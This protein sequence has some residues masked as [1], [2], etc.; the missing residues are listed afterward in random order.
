[1]KSR[2]E[3]AVH[4]LLIRNGTVVD[5]T[6]A[7]RRRADVA[8]SGGRITA[9]GTDLGPAREQLDADGLLVTPGFV[10]IHTHFDAQVLWDSRMEPAVWHG[11]TTAIM[12]NCGVGFAPAATHNRALLMDLM[13]QVEDIPMS[14]LQE[15][16]AWNWE[17]YAEYLA[18]VDARPRT[19]DVGSMLTFASLRSFVMGERAHGDATADDIARMGTLAREAIDAGSLGLAVSR[20]V[21]HAD[22][23]GRSVPGTTASEAELTAIVRAMRESGRGLLEVSPQGIAFPEPHTIGEEA[24]MLMRVSEAT[25]CPLTFL[26]TQ[27]HFAPQEY[28]PVLEQC[29]AARARGVPVYPQVNVR[30]TANL[31]SFLADNHP[32]RALPS[33][34]PF[35]SMPHAERVA[36]LRD[37]EVRARILAD[38]DPHPKGL[39]QLFADPSI[40]KSTYLMGD[41]LN[42]YPR[43]EQRI[44]VLAARAG[45]EPRAL[46]YDRMLDNGGCGFLMYVVSN[47]ATEDEAALFEMLHSPVSVVGLN[48]SGAHL[49]AVADASQGTTLLTHFVRDKASNEPRRLSLEAAIKKLAWDNAALFG[50]RDRGAIAPGLRADINL[51]DFDALGYGALEMIHDLP[52]KQPRLHQSASGF[53]AI[54]VNGEIIARRGELTGALPGRVARC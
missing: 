3:S 29:E 19:I 11:T 37:P 53:E 13:A 14:T 45:V 4:E 46:A 47:W 39:D 16:L 18:V 33:F 30:P 22:S 42:Y 9:I 12:G 20:T 23:Q 26:L 2:E 34:K 48:D 15:V 52:G 50:L 38:R 41:P 17:S 40:W 51:I 8:I 43:A 25:G 10:D 7:P 35:L 5:G 32:F 21:L 1:M 27:S 44:D 28:R 24:A 54:L 36:R 49:T 31:L 6:G